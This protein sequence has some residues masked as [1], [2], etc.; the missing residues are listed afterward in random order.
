MTRR[1]EILMVDKS[2]EGDEGYAYLALPVLR[3][4]DSDWNWQEEAQCERFQDMD[5]FNT[6]SPS[7]VAKCKMVCTSCMVR[8]QCLDF[9]KRN[10]IV[11]GIWGGQTPK[12]RKAS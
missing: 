6:G 5:F 8:T 10:G 2:Y 7:N 1:R 3:D 11:D 12:E 4:Q 9:A